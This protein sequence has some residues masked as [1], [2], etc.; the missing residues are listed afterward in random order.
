MSIKKLISWNVN[1]L[2]A[3]NNKGFLDFVGIVNPDVLCLQEIK[4]NQD[5]LPDE[6][7]PMEGY[8]AYFNSADKKGYSGTAIYSKIKPISVSYDLGYDEHDSEGRVITAEFEQFYLVNVYTPNAKSDLSR[9]VYREEW[10]SDFLS[11]L[12]ELEKTKPVIVCGDLNVAHKEIDLAR[13]K[14][15]VGSAGFTEEERRGFSN[16]ID[17]GFI[18]TFRHFNQDPDHYS[19]WSYRGGARQRNVGWRIDY[20]CASKSIKDHLE[21]AFILPEVLGSDHCPVGLHVTF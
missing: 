18:D 1:G 9:L 10:D 14:S 7:N 3:V 17:A 13:P 16:I 2:R 12:K 4:A 11:H 5:Q 20:F 8:F 21:H 6:L 19:W 15:N